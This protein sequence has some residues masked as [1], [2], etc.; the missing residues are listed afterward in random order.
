M[1]TL[2]DYQVAAINAVKQ[3]FQN[4][5]VALLQM[6]TGLGKTVV[7]TEIVKRRPS[8]RAL[9]LAHREEL[10]FQAANRLGTTA[11]EMADEKAPRDAPIVVG[12]VQT[13]VR[14]LNRLP[15]QEFSL[16]VI[17]EAHHAAAKTYCRIINWFRANPNCRILGV[18]ATPFRHD[19]KD[20]ESHFGPPVYKYSLVNG[21]E[22]GWLVP[23]Q[24]FITSKVTVDLENVKVRHGDYPVEAIEDQLKEIRNVEAIASVAIDQPGKVLV[25]TPGVQSAMLVAQ[26]LNRKCP[27]V[28]AVIHGGTDKDERRQIIE[29]FR[30]GK[31]R[32]ITNCLVLTE[33]FDEPT[34]DTIVMARPTKSRVLYA[35]VMGRGMRPLPY[36]TD[37]A[38][39][40]TQRRIAIAESAKP[41]LTIIDVNTTGKPSVLAVDLFHEHDERKAKYIHQV[42]RRAA[43][44]GPINCQNVICEANYEY[45]SRVKYR[46]RSI[47]TRRFVRR[48]SFLDLLYTLGVPV[49]VNG[50][51]V[52]GQLATAL[53]ALGI[54]KNIAH[55]VTL[56][57][58]SRIF[59]IA[60]QR[61]AVGLASFKQM[62]ILVSRGLPI[63]KA[64]A[65][66]KAEAS[67][68]IG[69]LAAGGWRGYV[70]NLDVQ[71]GRTNPRW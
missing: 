6:A 49:D 57:Q 62:R 37:A 46:L 15:A 17:D 24:E 60:R 35:Q 38:N 8:G 11:I 20:L 56:E 23:V 47:D 3:A 53:E 2:R 19:G 31:I 67:A 71:Q 61:K 69:K 13:V 30:S 12:T 32:I 25:Y 55:N 39:D 66:T 40:S 9:I 44:K 28:A 45:E 65:A 58:C 70:R 5:Q 43:K 54:P 33:G 59:R 29:D 51:P 18:T 68:T 50:T 64:I 4:R 52:P 27:G 1:I 36:I 63:E 21:I 42:A 26:S 16:V 10:V 14:R 48:D 7:F 22:D 34:V 41:H